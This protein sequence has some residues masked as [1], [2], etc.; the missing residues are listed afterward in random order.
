MS[1][2]KSLPLGILLGLS[3]GLSLAFIRPPRPGEIVYVYQTTDAQLREEIAA[4]RAW[5]ELF[6]R[7][8]QYAATSE[9]AATFTAWAAYYAGIAAHAEPQLREV[10]GQFGLTPSAPKNL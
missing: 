5:E 6:V 9:E 3:I 8:A 7:Y 10:E 2:A 1:P 4:A